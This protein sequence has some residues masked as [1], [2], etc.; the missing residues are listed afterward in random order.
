MKYLLIIVALTGGP[1]EEIP[2]PSLEA[3]QS[4]ARE[5]TAST[6]TKLVYVSPNGKTMAVCRP[7]N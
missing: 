7:A 3:C 6:G 5:I 1:R 2:L 4:A